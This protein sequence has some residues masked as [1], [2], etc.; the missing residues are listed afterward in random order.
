MRMCW[1]RKCDQYLFNLLKY[2]NKHSCVYC[3]TG[4]H[5]W[6]YELGSAFI[7]IKSRLIQINDSNFTLT[8]DTRMYN[9]H[10]CS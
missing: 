4:H 8:T 10:Y 5:H 7:L 3:Q 9:F 6:N 2:G 1:V